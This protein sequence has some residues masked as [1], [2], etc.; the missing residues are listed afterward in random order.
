MEKITFKRSEEI[1]INEKLKDGQCSEFY[2][3]QEQ[4][5]QLVKQPVKDHD[6]PVQI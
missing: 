4:I 5:L 3:P 1:Q 6:A 2:I